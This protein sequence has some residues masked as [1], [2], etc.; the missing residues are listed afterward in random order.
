MTRATG[1]GTT[2]NTIQPASN[3]VGTA[4]GWKKIAS[5]VSAARHRGPSSDWA[6]PAVTLAAKYDGN[7]SASDR[8][9][10]FQPPG[11]PGPRADHSSVA[12][13]A[14]SPDPAVC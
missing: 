2:G 5:A 4:G 1:E 14:D 13:N 12:T 10:G 7:R 6:S 9:N 11:Q 3:S 8:P